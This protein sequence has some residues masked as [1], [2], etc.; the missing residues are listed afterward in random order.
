MV[1]A[2]KFPIRLYRVASSP[3]QHIYQ[4]PIIPLTIL[5]TKSFLRPTPLKVAL[6]AILPALI[7][8]LVTFKVD[9]VYSFYGWLLTSLVTVYTGVMYKT[10]NTWVLAWIPMYLFSCLVDAAVRRVSS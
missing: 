1:N 10:F 9:S 3:Q 7:A 2:L 6:T 5:D 8:Y 4:P